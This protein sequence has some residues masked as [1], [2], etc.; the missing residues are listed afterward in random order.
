MAHRYLNCKVD[1]TE[2]TTMAGQKAGGNQARWCKSVTS[3]LSRYGKR[4]ELKDNTSYIAR[5]H[6]KQISKQKGWR[7]G[8]T[9]KRLADLTGVGSLAPISTIGSSQL[10]VTSMGTTLTSIHR[11]T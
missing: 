1:S 6:L 3:A 7:G 9:T 11:H 5:S 10:H 4:A 2:Y 8:S